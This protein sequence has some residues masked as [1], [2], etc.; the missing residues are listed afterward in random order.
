MTILLTGGA[1]FIGSHVAEALLKRKEDLVIVDDMNDY[2]AVR[3]KEENLAVLKKQ[4]KFAFIKADIRDEKTMG[5]IF[6]K[7][8]PAA[9]IHIAARAGVR[10]S[11]A[12]PRLYIDVNVNGTATLL[13]MARLHH[14]KAFIFASSSSVYGEN[15]KVPFS[16]DDPLD[17]MISPYAVTK[18]LC[19]LLAFA[20]QRSYPLHVT[21]LRFFTVYGPRGRPDMAPRKFTEAI[22]AGKPIEMYGDGMSK[23]DYTCVTDIVAGVLLALDKNL[24][25]EIINLGNNHPVELSRFIGLIE[26]EVG[27]KAVITRLPMQTGDVPVTYAD[28]TKAKRLLDWEPKVKIEEGIKE[29]VLWEKKQH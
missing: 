9:I 28:I 6:E 1:G 29:L 15:T 16:E 26:K 4:G 25:F 10:P 20:Y 11:L 21:C 5:K 22:M 2:Y 23:R 17:N 18:R 3:C 14:V 8:E 13:D 19:E 7:H 24:P 12:D 27:K